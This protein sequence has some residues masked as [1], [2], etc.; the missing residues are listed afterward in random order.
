MSNDHNRNDTDD[1]VKCGKFLVL[2]PRVDAIRLAEKDQK[3]ADRN[4]CPDA[5][6]TDTEVKTD[7]SSQSPE[8]NLDK[9]KRIHLGQQFK[10]L[11]HYILQCVAIK[12]KL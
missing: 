7:C 6:I 12:L 2:P 4:T 3:E 8:K 5:G 11:F 1:I 10:K 9:V